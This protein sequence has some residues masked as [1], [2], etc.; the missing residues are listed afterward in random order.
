MP[1]SFDFASMASMMEESRRLHPGTHFVRPSQVGHLEDLPEEVLRYVLA[2]LGE[3]GPA[4]VPRLSS[5]QWLALLPILHPHYVLPLLYRRLRAL[6]ES[7][8]PPRPVVDRLRLFFMESAARQFR[9][10]EQLRHL[11]Q[12]LEAG[13]VRSLVLKGPALGRSVYP[14]AASRPTSD[15]DILTP[16]RQILHSRKVMESMGYRCI[17]RSFEDSRDFYHDETFAHPAYPHGV[18]N[19]WDLHYLSGIG[20]KAGVEDFFERAVAI[21]TSSAAFY[22]LAPVDALVHRALNSAYVHD[23]NMRLVWICDVMLLARSLAV[24]GDWEDLLRRSVEW[25]AR[26]ALEHSLRLARVWLGYEPPVE[27]R[28]F[29]SWPAPSAAESKAWGHVVRR[30]RSLLSYAR[31][32]WSEGSSLR[33]K[34]RYAARVVF[35]KSAYVKSNYL[36]KSHKYGA[37]SVAGAYAKRWLRRMKGDLL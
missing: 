12:G 29:R 16:P 33:E 11:L 4:T 24:P 31:L 26:L 34:I 9:L 35:P 32:H 8:L 20:R 30:N 2:V 37:D 18:E 15:I 7:S 14:E 36:G 5:E 25:R 13:G 28:D 22:A 27:F 10:E 19:H 3:R 1:E 6:P 17:R 21:E 23:W